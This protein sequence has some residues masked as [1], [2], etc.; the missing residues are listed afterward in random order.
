MTES[1]VFEENRQ[2]GFGVLY[3]YVPSISCYQ[4]S[5]VIFVGW[6]CMVAGAIQ[7]AQ[8]ILQAP[9]NNSTCIDFEGVENATELPVND[10]SIDCKAYN[11]SFYLFDE[12]IDSQFDLV[13]SEKSKSAI[14]S[15]L[16]LF[17]HFIG[18]LGLGPVADKFG[19]RNAL[20][21]ASIF[22]TIFS[23]LTALASQNLW[24]FT[25]KLKK[26]FG[27]NFV[28]WR[29][30]AGAFAHGIMPIAGTY[31]VE[32]FGAKHRSYGTALNQA[33]FSVGIAFLSLAGWLFGDWHNQALAI[34][35]LP[36]VFFFITVCLPESIAFSYR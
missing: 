15:S 33:S 19:R 12:T 25:G 16:S 8:I 29:M 18:A 22:C 34:V 36:A 6:G 30:L 21:I 1:E 31:C 3:D 32:H 20:L 27:I 11:H 24:L 23:L 35:A 7:Y 26:N 10:C 14:I 4:V 9:P 13:C 17:G 28:V 2:L 5:L